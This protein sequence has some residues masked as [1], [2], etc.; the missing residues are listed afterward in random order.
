LS[1]QPSYLC[2][3]DCPLMSGHPVLRH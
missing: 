2:V 1:H 3:I